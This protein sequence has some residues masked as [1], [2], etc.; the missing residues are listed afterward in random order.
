[1]A[2]ADRTTRRDAADINACVHLRAT[3]H[4]RCAA[5]PTL[6]PERCCAMPA[7]WSTSRG[8]RRSAYSVALKAQRQL[9][10]FMRSRCASRVRNW[11]DSAHRFGAADCR[12][13]GR[14]RNPIKI[15]LCKKAKKP[16]RPA[17][18]IASMSLSSPIRPEC[19]NAS[20]LQTHR[21]WRVKCQPAAVSPPTA[22]A[23]VLCSWK[24]QLSPAGSSSR[25]RIAQRPR[26]APPP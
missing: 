10:R 14:Y 23:I 22:S 6:V 19:C 21:I 12:Q 16:A 2:A 7:W 1:M 26:A 3:T 18:S 20:T 15:G 17:R 8:R 4:R 11:H 13:W 5:A 9:P 25:I 24:P